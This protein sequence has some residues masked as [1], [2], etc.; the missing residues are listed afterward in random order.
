MG[1]NGG[2]TGGDGCIVS[3]VVFNRLD[4]IYFL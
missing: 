2:G 3:G 1:S 4:N